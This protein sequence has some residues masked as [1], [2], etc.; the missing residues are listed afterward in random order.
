M[1]KSGNSVILSEKAISTAT[2]TMTFSAKAGQVALKGLAL[3]G[4]MVASFLAAFAF[5]AIITGI[6]N[7]IHRVDNAKDALEEFNSS[8]KEQKDNL[9]TQ[10]SWIN[11][12]GKRFEELSQG[13]DEFGHNIS[14]TTDEFSEYK[15][16]TSKIAEMFPTMIK[17]YNDQNDVILKNKGSVD[18]LTEAY[19]KNQEAYYAD[20]RS[21]SSD[22]F[23]DFKTAISD[24]SKNAKLI[25][26][27]I[28]GKLKLQGTK[29][30]VMS[31]DGSP[32]DTVDLANALGKDTFDKILEDKS[33]KD[34]LKINT[35]TFV[36]FD[37][38]APALQDVKAS[39]IACCN[40]GVKDSKSTSVSVLI[41][42][43]SLTLLSSNILSKVSLPNALARSTVSTGLPSILMTLPLVP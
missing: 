23:D 39:R 10:E 3:A 40:S 27:I 30:S 8:V 16:M 12:N 32:V 11:E 37:S 21:K 14:L 7:Y 5:Q 19:K 15:D 35:D 42:K 28:N 29:G 22:T 43:L 33:V 34:S 13:V 26:N 6:D 31:I 1:I 17:G 41:F 36:D 18:E 24:D 2:N 20:I 25:N 38:L 4:N 9:S